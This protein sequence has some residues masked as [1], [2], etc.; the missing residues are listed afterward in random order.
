MG[1]FNIRTFLKQAVKTGASDVHL[2]VGERPVLRKDGKM[3]K[4]DMP[5]LDDEDMERAIVTLLP[6]FDFNDIKK[7]MDL[8]FSFELPGVSRFRVNLSKQLGRFALVLR[9]ISYNIRQVTELNLPTVIQ[10]FADLNN[11]IVLVTGPTGS[12]KSTTLASIIEHINMK[13]PKHIITV[14]DPIEY[15]FSNKLSIIS[16]RQVEIDTM[17]FNDGIKYA[18]RQDPDVILI[19]EIRDRETAT[20]ALK[21]AETG[22]LV[23]ASLHTN[24]AIQ[25]INRIINMFE[26]QDR[27]L[28][29]E[30]VANTIRGVVAQKLVKTSKGEGRRP[31]VEIMV[32]TPTIKDYIIKNKLEDIYS[33]MKS[34]IDEMTTMNASLFKLY[35]EGAI[36]QDAAME[37]SDNKNE[38][39]QMLRGVF[40]GT[41]SGATY[42]E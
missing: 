12:G 14:E 2:H 27:D 10:S 6:A 28:I 18:L 21:A 8:D 40:S 5:Y 22:H 39:N 32:S 17:S 34:G 13:Y 29:R 42:Y 23:L 36:S 16:Q 33:I 38:F 15:L 7:N 41:G 19:G 37:A 9:L 1:N 35:Q 30:Q 20:A 24:D 3:V 11:G 25:T 4:I 26:P 31:I